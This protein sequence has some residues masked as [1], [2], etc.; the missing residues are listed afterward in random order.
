MSAALLT[1]FLLSSCSWAKDQN[2]AD[3]NGNGWTDIK[4]NTESWI[5]LQIDTSTW[6]SNL[7]IGETGGSIVTSSWEVDAK[8][9][10]S[11]KEIDKIIN[12]IAND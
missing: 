7:N 6:A 1:I 12:D 11:L 8:T 4:I 2:P 5:D 10:E 3:N 9:D